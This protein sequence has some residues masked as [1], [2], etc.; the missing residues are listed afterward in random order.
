MTDID[1][2][3]ISGFGDEIAE[4]PDEQLTVLGRLGI[5]HLDLRRAWDTGVLDLDD[6]D[7]QNLRGLLQKHGA[8]VSTIASPIGKTE[9]DEDAA[10]EVGR[11]ETAIELAQAFE[12]PYIRIFSFY[13]TNVNHER[14]R[15]EVMR[16]LSQFAQRAEQAGVTLLLENESLLWGD[17]PERCREILDTVSSAR[18]R[19]SFDTGNYAALGIPPCD[20]AYPLVKPYLV[21]MQI[22]DIRTAQHEHTVAGTGDGQIPEILAALKRDDYRG[23]LALEPH[24]TIAGKAGGFSGAERFGQAAAALQGLLANLGRADGQGSETTT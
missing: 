9:I 17:T 23:F 7:I 3:T 4:D 5:R 20:V 16:R 12:T 6:A 8:Q 21:H 19:V 22:K 15:D 1:G 18:L 13:L 10:F 24:L 2:F 14:S 11:L